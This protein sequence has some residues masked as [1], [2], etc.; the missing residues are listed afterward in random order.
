MA[1]EG[2]LS[3]FGLS[4]ILQLI[5]VQQKTGMLTVSSD[6]NAVVMFF[7]DGQIISTRDRRR[8][9]R[10]PFKEYLTRY[11]VLDREQLI[12][13]SQIAS[14]SKL[15]FTEILSSEGILDKEEV[16]RQWHKQIQEAM[17]EVLTWEQCSYKFIS[18]EEIVAGIPTLGDYSIEAMLMESMRRI[19]EF[20]QL[21]EM[22][23]RD[24]ILIA[25]VSGQKPDD[26]DDMTS[27]EKQIYRLVGSSTNLRDVIARGKL[28]VFEVYEALKL[29]KDR[30]LIQ[31]REPEVAS[32][33]SSRDGDRK[34]AGRR[35]RIGNPLPL[36]V[37]VGLFVG[38]VGFGFRGLAGVALSGDIPT[39][40]VG[41]DD[42]VA[43]ARVE[44]RLRWL[45][46]AFRA[47]HGHYPATLETLQKAGL[48]DSRL[49]AAAE[50]HEFRYQLTAGRSAYT[51]L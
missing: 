2:N 50:K 43:R 4:E 10:D 31:T 20:P 45:I 49:I 34:R 23:P 16:K 18:N 3:S 17:F 35:R 46:E 12:R 39:Q 27:N 1:L 32:A 42:A 37:A 21:L 40:W 26:D 7:R 47:Q 48:A 9:A 11:G 28:P 44:H 22:F 6:D 38:A 36:L 29:L 41:G 14:Q 19:D 30:N 5:A 25:R 24:D 15:D 8:R 33:A 13:I 51:L